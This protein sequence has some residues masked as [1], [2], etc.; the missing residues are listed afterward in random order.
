MEDFP[1]GGWDL[2]ECEDFALWATELKK[3][4]LTKVLRALVLLLRELSTNLAYRTEPL[5]F[6]D[7]GDGEDSSPPAKSGR[8]VL[9]AADT[10]KVKSNLILNVTPVSSVAN[11]SCPSLT[12]P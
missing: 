7:E 10:I 8:S 3:I 5:Q 6:E 2:D 1:A 11:V 4:P 9:P 12:P